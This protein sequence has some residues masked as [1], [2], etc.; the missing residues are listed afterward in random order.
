MRAV[1]HQGHGGPEILRAVEL[2]DPEPGP[3]EV[4]V[5]VRAAAVNRLDLLQR[6]GP[7]LLP[8]FTLPHVPGMDIAGDI[9]AVGGGVHERRVGDRVLVNP[10]LHCGRCTACRVG[11]DAWCA[12]LRVVG[13]NRPG[14]YAEFVVAPAARTHRVPAHVGHVAAASL[15]TAYG[16]AWQG[17]V[18]RGGLRP[19]ETL[20]VHGAGS[21]VSIAAVQLAQALGAR[22][23]VTSGSRAKLDRMAD[24][25]ADVLIDHRT[26]DLAEQAR[27]A[28]DGLG[29]D[30]VL[31][32]V[33][34]ALFQASL[35]AL[36]PRG[37]L[38]FCGDTTGTEAT[39]DLPHAFHSG[40]T[41]LGAGSCGHADFSAMVAFCLAHGLAPVV[42]TAYPL[43][44][45]ARAHRRLESGD[46]FGK[47]VLLPGGTS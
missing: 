9:V 47:V 37:R 15:P 24:L 28:T 18:V 19:G 40:V 16:M 8:G 21:G 33:G 44:D 43:A 4:L 38:V 35:H 39:F 46:A 10:A 31:D 22:V 13:G 34:P 17:L 32:H 41:L 14:G 5:A 12:A 2:P 45:A 26:S 29:V 7:G 23:V 6:R 20:L 42:D 3:G 1:R 36:R 30:L 27:A 11:D 25:G